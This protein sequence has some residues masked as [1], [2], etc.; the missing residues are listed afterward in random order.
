MVFV[1]LTA[2]GIVSFFACLSPCCCVAEKMAGTC[3]PAIFVT[4]YFLYFLFYP[5]Y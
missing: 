4:A 5:N 2:S 1:I 3:V